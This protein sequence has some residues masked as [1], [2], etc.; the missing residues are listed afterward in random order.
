MQYDRSMLTVNQSSPE[1]SL[2]ADLETE[3]TYFLTFKF[4]KCQHWAE[5]K[6]NQQSAWIKKV[7]GHGVP[8]G[9]CFCLTH[10]GASPKPRT[11]F[12]AKSQ[13]FSMVKI[14][15]VL[16]AND[17][18]MLR[19]FCSNLHEYLICGP[20]PLLK[21]DVLIFSH[22][23]RGLLDDGWYCDSMHSVHTGSPQPSLGCRTGSQ[24]KD[25]MGE[26]TICVFV[27][28]NALYFSGITCS[29]P[30]IS[31]Q[32]NAFKYFTNMVL[33][34]V[35]EGHNIQCLIHEHELDVNRWLWKPEEGVRSPGPSYMQLLVT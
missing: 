12:S 35:D 33:N 26:G 10:P 30:F 9:C 28:A 23:H 29:K 32:K 34:L 20:T 24:R 19:I 7:F 5:I 16:I 27:Q 18:W 21:Y 3:Y 6:S 1:G 8:D 14:T 13:R 11:S 31:I 2:S 17:F 15:C 22:C 4:F 25:V